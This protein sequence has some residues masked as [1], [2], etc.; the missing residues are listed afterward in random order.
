MRG[1]FDPFK[2]TEDLNIRADY[3]D[4]TM[5]VVSAD[6]ETL[7]GFVKAAFPKSCFAI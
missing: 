3:Y 2:W 6:C 1:R 4:S 5:P 7:K